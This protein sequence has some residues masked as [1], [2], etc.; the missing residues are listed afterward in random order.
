MGARSVTLGFSD[1][2][3]EAKTQEEDAE[4]FAA[5]SIFSPRKKELRSESYKVRKQQKN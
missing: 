2:A 4:E 1:L 5:P 3:E